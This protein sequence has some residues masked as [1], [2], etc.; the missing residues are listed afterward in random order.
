MTA[1]A[2]TFG[3]AAGNR[4]A[5]ATAAAP[6]GFQRHAV[7][8]VL[9]VQADIS[10][11]HFPF[12]TLPPANGAPP[13]RFDLSQLLAPQAVAQIAQTGKLVFHIAGDS[14]DKRGQQMDF[15]ASMMTADFD[16]SPAGE[17]P[18][19]F[20]HLGDVVYFAGDIADYPAC[21]Y[22]TYAEYPGPIVSIVGNH[23]CQPDDP[24]DSPGGV[25][26]PNKV[27]FDGW[28]QNFMSKDPTQLGSLKT[29]S[30]RTQMNLPNAYWT[31]TTPL[32]TIIGLCSN[33][34]ESQAEIHQDQIDW[35][36]GELK[37][38]DPAKALI[39]AIHHPPFS[40]D[41]EHSGSV[42]AETVLF[43]AFAATGVWPHLVMSGHVHNYQRFTTKETGGAGG[44]DVSCLVLGNSGY[45]RLGKLTKIRGEYPTAPLA[46]TD[47]LTLES[48]DHDNFGFARIEVTAQS[49][50][51]IYKSAP[52]TGKTEGV[53]ATE[54]MFEVALAS[55]AISTLPI[56]A[57]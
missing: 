22:E 46:V 39:V 26:D 34:S 49:I 10:L 13:Y 9:P 43:Q 41:Q 15:V 42:A 57:A 19:F 33:V 21:F 2:L 38:A 4:L 35:F 1:H 51:G 44:S 12:Q 55:H 30:Q 7:G 8:A 45:T 50:V 56:P 17:A 6:A 48:Y 28:V 16:A 36:Q 3:R 52:Y 53:G 24:Q 31:F 14:G 11:P 18:A 29:G 54:D 23:D 25:V 32:A 20:Y 40:G 47:A 27:P 37:A 5:S